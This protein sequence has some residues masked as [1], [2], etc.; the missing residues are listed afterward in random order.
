MLS[1]RKNEAIDKTT[2]TLQQRDRCLGC[3]RSRA[4][5]FC[6]F[7]KPF[8]T[9]TRFVLLMHPKEYKRQTTGTGRMTHQGLRNSEILVNV[10]FSDSKRLNTLLNDSSYYPVILYPGEDSINLSNNDP[11][12]IPLRKTLLIIILDGTWRLAKKIRTASTNLHGIPRICFTPEAAS[13]YCFKRQPADFCVSTIEATYYL[14]DIL[15]KRGIENLHGIHS[16]LLDAFDSLVR[17]Q[18]S[19][20]DSNT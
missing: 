8:D 13:R 6:G 17:Y 1:N 14:L 15:D 4:T 12:E 3:N 18:L 5:C 10:N 2:D 19:Y 9:Q 20:I 7:I 16:S 11:F